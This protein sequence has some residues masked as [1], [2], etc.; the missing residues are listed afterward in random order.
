MSDEAPKKKSKLG[1]VFVALLV[2]GGIGAISDKL[3]SPPTTLEQARKA[4]IGVWIDDGLVMDRVAKIEFKTDGTYV[5]YLAVK[6]DANWGDI[7]DEG[8]WKVEE[9]EVML[10]N[11]NTEKAFEISWHTNDGTAEYVFEK[12]NSVYNRSQV[13]TKGNRSKP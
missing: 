6:G 13:M 4:A 12:K 7:E 5:S 8:S 10:E 2:I 9:T 3:N 11:G 1:I